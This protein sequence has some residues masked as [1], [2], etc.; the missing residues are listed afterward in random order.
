MYTDVRGGANGANG[1][2][3][4]APHTSEPSALRYTAPLTRTDA[5]ILDAGLRQALV[6]TQS[7]GRS[8]LSVGTAECP[9]LCDQRHRVPAFAS[10]WSTWH[11][12]LPIYSDPDVYAEGV[13]SLAREN[14]VRVVI[15]SSDG[16]IAALRPRRPSFEEHEIALALA[17]ESALAVAN[18]KRRTLAAAAE[19]GISGPRS[20]AIAGLEEARAALAEVGYPAVI[21]PT[22]SWVQAGEKAARFTPGAVMNEVEA[23]TYLEEIYEEYGSTAVIQEW[24]S[25]PRESVN[26]MYVN[27]RVVAEIA[28]VAYRTAPV[29]GGVNVVRATIPMPDDLRA[30]AH[31]LIGELGVEGYSEVEFRR[32]SAGRPLIMEIN[33]RLTAG[34]ELA[35]RAGVDFPALVWRWA[36][37]EPIRPVAGYR[38]GVRMRFLAGD[39]EWLW[40][41]IKR[42]GRAD[43]VPP[44]RAMG[45]FVREFL[46][47]QS[48]DYFHRDDLRPAWVALARDLGEARRRF[49]TKVSTSNEGE[50][51]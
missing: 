33:A 35:N 16:A 43:S 12:D 47:P 19:L 40:E 31:S 22:Q 44:V 39:L 45:M 8:G 24:V 7:L 28:Q 17:S 29:L 5:L 9:D 21:K 36:A 46:R 11:A 49:V 25:G 32:D 37:G 34:V 1:L 41:N 10:R 4:P 14:G 15:P 27:G 50:R 23:L 13:L 51:G 48:Y 2:S 20:F 26:L 30:A 38:N 18:D 42:P 6:A 3:S